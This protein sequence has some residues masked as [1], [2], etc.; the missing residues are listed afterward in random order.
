MWITSHFT[1]SFNNE[2]IH[3]FIHAFID[4]PIHSCAYWFTDS[5]MYLLIFW[6]IY[7]FIQAV[8]GT[9]NHILVQSRIIK[10]PIKHTGGTKPPHLWV[11]W[12]LPLLTQKWCNSGLKQVVWIIKKLLLWGWFQSKNTNTVYMCLCTFK[13]TSLVLC[14]MGLTRSNTDLLSA[15]C[16]Q[17]TLWNL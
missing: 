17:F 4:S 10:T 13:R 9:F 16:K 8:P 3:W 15:V 6:F 5:L 7:V 2:L 11:L 14:L 12:I 1:Y